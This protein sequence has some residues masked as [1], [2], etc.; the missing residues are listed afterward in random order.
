MVI[1]N[2]GGLKSYINI[3]ADGRLIASGHITAT[4]IIT[5]QK[6]RRTRFLRY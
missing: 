4:I 6:S 5:F 3:L 2:I 1:L